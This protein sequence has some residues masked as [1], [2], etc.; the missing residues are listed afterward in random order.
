MGKMDS[1]KISNELYILQYMALMLEIEGLKKELVCDQNILQNH[2][3]LRRRRYTILK[4]MP[5]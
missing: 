5:Y 3:K 4:L 1:V 2:H